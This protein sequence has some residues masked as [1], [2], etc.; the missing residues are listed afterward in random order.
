MNMVKPNKRLS[1]NGYRIV[2]T[3][4]ILSAAV[5]I[6]AS[7]IG[8]FLLTV[9]LNRDNLLPVLSVVHNI[10]LLIIVPAN[11]ITFITGIIFSRFTQWGFFKHRWITLKY[12]INL[13]PITGGFIFASAIINMLSIADEIGAEALLAPSFIMSRNIFTWAFIVMLLLLITAVCLTVFK[14]EL[15]LNK[16][17]SSLFIMGRKE[18]MP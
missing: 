9:V 15:K 8:L 18:G 3:L 2:K 7:I 14:P 10:D 1:A 5:W 17:G 6:G 16:L 4:H 11:L 13:I 12:I